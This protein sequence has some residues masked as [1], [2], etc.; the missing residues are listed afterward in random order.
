VG[1]IQT[2]Y[3]RLL[4]PR[5]G[6][7]AGLGASLSVSLVPEALKPHYGGTAALGLGVFA[8]LRPTAAP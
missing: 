5:R 3:L 6:V 4:A 2:G 1:K 8:T 7:Q